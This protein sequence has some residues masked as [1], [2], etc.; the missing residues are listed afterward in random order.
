MS[1]V[2]KIIFQLRAINRTLGIAYAEKLD[3]YLNEV[4]R[5]PVRRKMWI[6]LNGTRLPNEIA[7]E[8]DVSPAAVTYFLKTITNAR[9]VEYIQGQ[10]PRKIIDHIPFEWLIEVEDE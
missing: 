3:A 4:I 7:T 2:E 8:V 5:T 9:I 10:P 6:A 1:D